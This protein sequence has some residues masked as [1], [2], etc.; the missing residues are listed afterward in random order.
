MGIAGTVTVPP[1]LLVLVA[2]VCCVRVGEL[3]LA[4]RNTRWTAARGGVEYGSRSYPA[5]IVLHTGLILGIL[6][7]VTLAHRPFVPLL[8]WSAVAALVLVQAVRGWCMHA[9]GPLW[10]TRIIV[11]P[12][13]PLVRHGPYRFM[14]H[15][16]YTAVVLEGIA[17]PMVHGAWL[18]AAVFTF[19][20][21]PFLL[22]WARAEDRALRLAP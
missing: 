20:N 6:I 11:V 15:P 7:E 17:L 2:A 4:R 19:L 8:G 12:G 1:G 10:N 16:N 13:H 18:T 21:T 14:R 9:L 5:V 3:S 22:F